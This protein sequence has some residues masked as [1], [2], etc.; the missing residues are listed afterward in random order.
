MKDTWRI[1]S[2]RTPRATG[3]AYP[4]LSPRISDWIVRM[5]ILAET[6]KA[7]GDIHMNRVRN[8]GARRVPLGLLLRFFRTWIRARLLSTCRRE[9]ENRFY[10][11]S[12]IQGAES[13]ETMKMICSAAM[14]QAAPGT[15]Y[16]SSRIGGGRVCPAPLSSRSRGA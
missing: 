16:E 15:L 12:R 3:P 6:K 11:G 1:E 8:A 2:R 10:E 9:P 4:L 14:T 5:N 7:M 13:W